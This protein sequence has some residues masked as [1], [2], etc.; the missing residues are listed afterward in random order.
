MSASTAP[1]SGLRLDVGQLMAAAETATGLS[2]WGKDRTFRIGLDKLAESM[3]AMDAP[4]TLVRQAGMRLTGSLITRLHFVE[5]EKQH[6]E[7]LQ[8]KIERPL[9]IVGLPRTGTTITYDLLALDP[10]AR[11]PR[12]WEFA[13]PWPA[14]EIATWDSDPRIAQ[15]DAIFA[16]LLQGAPKLRDIQDIEARACAECN[17]AFTHHFA[18]TQFPAEWGL[19]S[20]GKWLRENPSVPGRYA[21][22][23]RLLQQLQWKGPRG[24]WTLK[25]PEHLCTIEELL[26]VFPGACLVWTH[27]D[28][29]SAFSSLS[30]MLNE[31]RKAA[32]V[33]EDPLAVGRYVMET[34]SNALEHATDVRNRKP[35]VDRA[36]IDISHK[37]VIADR[38]E[39]VKRI[40]RYFKLPF[41]AVHE[42]ALHSAAMKTI[43][44]RFGKHSHKP[45]DFGITR[46]EVRSLLPKYLARFGHFFDEK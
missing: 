20:Y 6:P 13:M 36:V 7:V 27:R 22:H 9:V 33:K 16:H 40:H 34:W 44:R 41:T 18:S 23:K 21:T 46:D 15:L 17:L 8:E 35:E 42:A 39:V 43:S 5:D 26:E 45:E 37:E 1:S 3:N 10:A 25:S 2:D 38:V 12:N 30:S 32:G 28:P 29:V 31:F 19:I 24:R 14:P 4:D 11:A